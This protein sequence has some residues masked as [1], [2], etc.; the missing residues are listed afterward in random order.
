LPNGWIEA[1]QDQKPVRRA[2]QVEK[3]TDRDLAWLNGL[4][5]DP[6]Q[7]TDDDARRLADLSLRYPTA[8][9]EQ[10]TDGMLVDRA[11]APVRAHHER[12]ARCS[13]LLAKA[14]VTAQAAGTRG[15]G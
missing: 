1:V 11:F 14:N 12:L 2:D 5:E 15:R 4:P 3:L 6:A 10:S 13:D 7:V 8:L 9:G